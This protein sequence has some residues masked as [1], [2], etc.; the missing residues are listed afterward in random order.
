MFNMLMKM[1][2]CKHDEDEDDGDED[3]GDEDDA[4]GDDGDD[5]LV[6]RLSLPQLVAQQPDAL[7][8]L[9]NLRHQP[10]TLKFNI[11]YGGT[12]IVIVTLMLSSSLKLPHD[13]HTHGGACPCTP[14]PPVLTP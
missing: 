14:Q 2:Q 9:T 3:D 1:I 12:C 8:D 6:G 11:T 10:A 7:L 4:D 13:D 5:D